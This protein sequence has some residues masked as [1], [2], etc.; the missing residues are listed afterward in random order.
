MAYCIEIVSKTPESDIG[1]CVFG[2]PVELSG[3]VGVKK[4]PESVLFLYLGG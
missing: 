1:G 4:W 2:E 3:S